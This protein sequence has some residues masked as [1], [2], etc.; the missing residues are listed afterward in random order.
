VKWTDNRRQHILTRAHKYTH[1]YPH[2]CIDI[3]EAQ[4]DVRGFERHSEQ[5]QCVS[6]RRGR[7]GLCVGMWREGWECFDVLNEEIIE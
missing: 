6:G 2:T 1:I 4:G 5:W 3:G 7:G